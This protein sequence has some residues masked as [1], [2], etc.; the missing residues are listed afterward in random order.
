MDGDRAAIISSS[1]IFRVVFGTGMMAAVQ[2]LGIGLKMLMS[3]IARNVAARLTVY[4]AMVGCFRYCPV[5]VKR[6]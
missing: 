2:L 3:V 4:V 5:L 6:H 1:R